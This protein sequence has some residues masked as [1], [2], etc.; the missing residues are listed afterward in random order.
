[1]KRP[2]DWRAFS[3]SRW[4]QRAT[5]R[6]CCTLFRNW[7]RKQRMQL[8][9]IVTTVKTCT[10][11][12]CLL[13]CD[14]RGDGQTLK[15]R[16][17]PQTQQEMHER[18]QALYSFH[19]S[20]LNNAELKKKSDEMDRF[21]GDVKGNTDVTLPLL[22]VELRNAQK[23]SFFLTDG[24]ELLLDLSKTSEDKQLASDALARTDLR[25]TQSGT[26]FFTVHNLACD[27][28]NTTAAALHILDDPAFRV[29]VPQHAMVLDQRMAL[30]YLLLSMKDD[31]W[32][33]PAEER[34]TNEKNANAKLA[35]VFA[36][37]YA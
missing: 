16:S 8:G 14:I 20:Q 3:I 5:P 1:M 9:R 18:V 13:F 33:K 11:F 6:C 26:Y 27:G 10:I 21:W 15:T 31:I 4:S 36:F 30:M 22:R 12:S 25:D 7:R 35:I 34:F 23:G 37:S 17:I 29:S 28:I 24:S 19:P 2:A 32:V